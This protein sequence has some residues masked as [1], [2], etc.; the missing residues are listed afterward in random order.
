MGTADTTRWEGERVR[1]H[2][3]WQAES[4]A[5]ESEDNRNAHRRE[6]GR[7]VERVV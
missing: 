1:H 2:P 3:T 4:R 7:E 6:G 5:K